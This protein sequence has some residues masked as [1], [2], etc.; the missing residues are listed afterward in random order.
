MFFY[1]ILLFFVLQYATFFTIVKKN[2]KPVCYV[3]NRCLFLFLL[4]LKW[5]KNKNF[6]GVNYQAQKFVQEFAKYF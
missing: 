5:P 3:C 6:Y 2:A 4:K 1:C